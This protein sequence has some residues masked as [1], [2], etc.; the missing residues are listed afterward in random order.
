MVL[1]NI[2]IDLDGDDID[3]K[4]FPPSLNNYVSLKGIADNGKCFSISLVPSRSHSVYY[5]E[6]YENWFVDIIEENFTIFKKI[7]VKEISLFYN[8][9]FSDQCNIE[10]FDRQILKK[11][12]KYDVA[13]PFSCYVREESELISYLL[14]SGYTQEEIDEF[15]N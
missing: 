8:L 6:E 4:E 12:A 5:N 9:L 1:Q 10:I 11:L 13:I 3:L 7:G 2:T 15:N 14:Q